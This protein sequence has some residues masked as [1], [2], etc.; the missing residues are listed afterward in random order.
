MTRPVPP[1]AS[2]RTFQ[3][4]MGD[5]SDSD[6]EGQAFFAGGSETSGQQILGPKRPKKKGED[7]VKEMFQA[8]KG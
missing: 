5:D 4:M 8:A 6:E 3:G 7:I 1:P 2:I